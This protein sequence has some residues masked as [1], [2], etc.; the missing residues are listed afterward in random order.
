MAVAGAF[1]HRRQEAGGVEVGGRQIDRLGRNVRCIA[2]DVG[3]C[4][5]DLRSLAVVP[6]LG[7]GTRELGTV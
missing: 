7:R 6:E 4:L 5:V 1:R 2:G 3:R